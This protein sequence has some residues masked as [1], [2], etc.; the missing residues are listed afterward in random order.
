M[1]FLLAFILI[2]PL[3]AL[4]GPGDFL[5]TL[6][7]PE[8]SPWEVTGAAGLGL[9]SGNA[10][11]L[12][13]SLQLLGTYKKGDASGHLGADL[14]YSDNNGIATTNN[15]RI[16]G[17]YDHPL[18]ERFYLG[19]FGTLLTD[20]LADLDY[21]FD[22]GLTLGYSLIKTAET[23]LTLEAGPAYTWEKQDGDPN[24]YVSA[25]FAQRFE[26][27]LTDRSKFWQSLVIAPQLSNFENNLLTA[28]AGLD[29]LLTE[30]WGLRTS[31]RYQYDTT[32]ARGRDQED[33]L[34]LT[35]LTYTLGG[36]AEP[37]QKSRRS[38]RPKKEKA[39]TIKMGWSTTG[40]FNFS[41]ASGNA[42]NLLVGLALDS[43][44][45]HQDFE[46][47]LSA[48]YNFTQ[49]DGDTSADS[50]RTNLQHNRIL[51]KH[52]FIGSSLAYFRD[53]IADVNYRLTPG[54]SAGSYLVK[55]DD[56]TFSIEAGPGYTFEQVG[57]VDDEF[58]S[59]NLTEKFAWDLNDDMSLN[60]SF[61]A[62]FDP[63]DGSDYLLTATLSLDTSL[64]ENL[65]WRLAAAWNRDNTPARN[66]GKNDSTLTSGISVKF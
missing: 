29:L 23:K 17:E 18:G 22:T 7:V 35:G 30:E 15:F 37:S 59:L 39:K 45:R 61:A 42:D 3:H 4:P 26:H 40:A 44:H 8:D 41:L 14:L 2:A 62:T 5:K 60:Q 34:L 32:P 24:N 9:A 65:S 55:N 38:L 43:A 21:R 58:L 16:Y 27:N 63:S 52:F 10:D 57:G 51:T 25:R 49:N 12:T 50:L 28:E 11:T 33:L 1:K 47:F 19:T 66:R 53:D 48:I 36:I 31:V 46:T 64:T 6:S 56:L 13:Y 20:D 54:F